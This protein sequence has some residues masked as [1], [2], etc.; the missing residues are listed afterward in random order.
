MN[1]FAGLL[2]ILVVIQGYMIVSR[3]KTLRERDIQIAALKADIQESERKLD[4]AQKTI[5]FKT[6]T[7]RLMGSR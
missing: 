7:I 2:L 1:K 4:V 3:D 5:E 6:L